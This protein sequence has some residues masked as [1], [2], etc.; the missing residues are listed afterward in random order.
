MRAVS[1]TTAN[2]HDLKQAEVI[3][4]D[5]PGDVYGDTAYAARSF[6]QAIAARGGTAMIVQKN[7]WSRDPDALDKWNA[8]VRRVRCRIEKIFGTWKRS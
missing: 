8:G 3:L 4:P 6:E 2:V 5:V 1:V 7:M